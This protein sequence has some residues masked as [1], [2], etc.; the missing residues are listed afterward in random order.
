MSQICSVDL[1]L[2][3]VISKSSAAFAR[4]PVI[5]SFIARAG[6][7]AVSVVARGSMK[8]LYPM[9]RPLDGIK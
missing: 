4:E 5:A 8:T 9:H 7:D 2:L 1:P 6:R 3:R